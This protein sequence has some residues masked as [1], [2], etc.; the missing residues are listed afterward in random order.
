MTA[1]APS[2][3]AG[4][5]KAM[6]AALITVAIVVGMPALLIAIAG[7]PWTWHIPDPARLD[8]ALSW[9]V[10]AN[11]VKWGL[12]LL[13]WLIWVCL[14][15]AFVREIALQIAGR[16]VTS[17]IQGPIRL[18]AATLTGTV[19][20]TA[21]ALAVSAEPTTVISAP[22]EECATPSTATKD[23]TAQ[24]GAVDAAD[25]GP[26][27]DADGNILH[28]VTRETTLWG[29]ADE[30]YKDPTLYPK[31]FRAN[32]GIVQANGTLLTDP[33]V[34]VDGTKI[35]IPDT[36]IPEPPVE[37]IPDGPAP[38]E[39]D[40]GLAEP[41]DSQTETETPASPAPENEDDQPTDT[42]TAEQETSAPPAFNRGTWVSAGSFIAL[43][44]IAIA[45][46]LRRKRLRENEIEPGSAPTPAAEL[47]PADDEEVTGR[48]VDL[49]V[50]LDE[51][52]DAEEPDTALPLA[53][54]TTATAEI[55]VLNHA[56]GGLGL[57]GPGA[58]S[59]ARGALWTS[60]GSEVNVVIDQGTA[61]TLG[62]DTDLLRSL[63]GARLVNQDT[64][65]AG[66]LRRAQAAVQYEPEADELQPKVTVLISASAT[67]LDAFTGREDETYAL[68]LGAWD[69]AWIELA[70]DGTP[71]D[72]SLADLE[73][74]QLGHC[75]SIGK[76]ECNAM[77]A[78][79]TGPE[80]VESDRSE[81]EAEVEEFD[82]TKPESEPAAPSSTLDP[83]AT[84]SARERRFTLQLF[85]SHTLSWNGTEVH[86]GRKACAE[87]IAVMALSGWS[88]TRDELNEVVAADATLKQ[89]KSRRTTIVG[90]ARKVLNEFTG[91]EEVLEFYRARE[92]Y[93][94]DQSWFRTDIE[95]FEERLE[96][97]RNAGDA[98][99][100]ARHLAE[101]LRGYVGPVGVDLDEIWDL[102]DIR[103][104]YQDQ[105]YQA[106]IDLARLHQGSGHEDQAA[107]VLERASVI[108]PASAEAWQLLADHHRRNGDEARA[109]LAQARAHQ[110]R[111]TNEGKA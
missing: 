10:P 80:T 109:G 65:L 4:A 36:A 47:V 93:R 74:D 83:A 25:Q 39:P 54:G 33:D 23:D 98:E 26:E 2:R 64:E 28:T 101:A 77:L 5:V 49:Q 104:S 51:H 50:L 82:E 89:A 103:K 29:L 108:N 94:L 45:V 58:L 19:A 43:S 76:Q 87:L 44:A 31:I 110:H 9:P 91:T 21:P 16:R 15:I 107:V 71:T 96:Q 7:T 100:H 24:E 18:L 70:A 105:A 81:P 20:A 32:Q 1:L 60:L 67:A 38:P 88:L 95:D 30:Y 13:A 34:I 86:F 35:V 37:E 75:Y 17:Q 12:V 61:D 99:Q 27:R 84:V 22:A 59:V 52:P 8:I 6:I 63:P 79:L 72:C 66:E 97:A 56:R 48:L 14:V 111:Q 57:T 73:L 41:P 3:T 53:T 11:T 106:A 62:V 46:K 92:I 85:G 78:E 68:I 42:A 90:E 69:R 40:D 55:S 102:T